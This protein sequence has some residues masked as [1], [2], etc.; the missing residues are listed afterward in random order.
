MLVW[1][2]AERVIR[3]ELWSAVQ[4]ITEELKNALHDGRDG[5]LSGEEVAELASAAMKGERSLE[6]SE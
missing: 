3:G 4:A 1:A 5:Q 6:G 2:E